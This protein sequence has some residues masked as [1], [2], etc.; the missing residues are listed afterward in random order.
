MAYHQNA[1][2]TIHSR[3]RLAHAVVVDRCALK[4]AA[5]RFQVSAKWTAL[6]LLTPDRD[7]KDWG[8][9][10]G[11][12]ERFTNCPHDSTSPKWG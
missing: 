5:A 10:E 3:E 2:L 11:K 7:R 8:Q 6:V 12:K 9:S 4:A 1:R